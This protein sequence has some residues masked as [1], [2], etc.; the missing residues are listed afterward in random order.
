LN[1]G[2]VLAPCALALPAAVS[3]SGE[4][5]A[6]MAVTASVP[7]SRSRRWK[8]VAITS[9][10]VALEEALLPAFSDSSA[11]WDLLWGVVMAKPFLVCWPASPPA[12][13]DHEKTSLE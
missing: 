10:R 2:V 8:R 7:F 6:A 5:V 13:A 4:T 1:D 9:P 3:A 11:A 12:L